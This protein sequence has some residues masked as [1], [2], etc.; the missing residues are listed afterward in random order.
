MS[1][2]SKDIITLALNKHL[3]NK[4]KSFKERKKG[5][6]NREKCFAA[7][8]NFEPGSSKKVS[9]KYFFSSRVCAKTKFLARLCKLLLTF[10]LAEIVY[11]FTRI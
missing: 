3:N 7:D 5:F 1:R 6:S 11:I 10:L 4:I 2:R 9:C 8:P